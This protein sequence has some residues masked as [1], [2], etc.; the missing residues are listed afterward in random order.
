M[1]L[2]LDDI[3]W[4][5]GMA[6]GELSAELTHPGLAWFIRLLNTPTA[7]LIRNGLSLM[8][9]PPDTQLTETG[10]GDSHLRYFQVQDLPSCFGEMMSGVVLL[11]D[12]VFPPGASNIIR[13]HEI[14]RQY[15]LVLDWSPRF[16]CMV[17]RTLTVAVAATPCQ[18]D[19][20]YI[21]VNWYPGDQVAWAD[22]IEDLTHAFVNYPG[23]WPETGAAVPV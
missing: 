16:P 1:N 22:S 11:D 8:D 9:L 18:R 21:L 3:K 10:D 6:T 13:R 12:D 23:G 17:T 7:G 5:T 15:G 19:G 2:Q 14:S 20:K 4:F